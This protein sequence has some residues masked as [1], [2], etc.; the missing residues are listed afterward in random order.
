MRNRLS[1]PALSLC[2]ALALSLTFLILF[3]ES[4]AAGDRAA[5]RIASGHIPKDDNFA[6]LLFDFE[7]PKVGLKW[8]STELAKS[9][10]SRAFYLGAANGE[11][12]LYDSEGCRSIRTPPG[13]V[14]V[15]TIAPDTEMKPC[16]E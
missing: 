11:L 12:V 14:V 2:L 1:S 7:V 10:P 16:D 15:V 4:L 13:N 8:A 6:A 9:L 3:N 5:N